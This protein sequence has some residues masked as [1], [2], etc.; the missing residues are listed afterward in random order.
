MYEIDKRPSV[1]WL[2]RNLGFIIDKHQIN[3][4]LTRAKR[5]LIIIGWYLNTQYQSVRFYWQPASTAPQKKTKN[6]VH[7]VIY[8]STPKHKFFLSPGNQNLLV[9]DKM[10]QALLKYYREKKCVVAAEKFMQKE[11][12]T[13]RRNVEVYEH[14]QRKLYLQRMRSQK[15]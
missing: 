7:V 15:L 13:I 1:G 11:R 2:K 12:W 9:C 6:K 5:G 10:W 8:D 14:D 3:V 4:A